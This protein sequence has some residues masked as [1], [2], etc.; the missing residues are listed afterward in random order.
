MVMKN[1]I[2]TGQEEILQ[3]LHSLTKDRPCLR[4]NKAR[5]TGRQEVPQSGAAVGSSSRRNRPVHAGKKRE[6]GKF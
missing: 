6:P 4:F 3:G 1:E 2:L 5:G